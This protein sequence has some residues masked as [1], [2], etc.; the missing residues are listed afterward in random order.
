MV[1]FT[2]ASNTCV[3]DVVWLVH[4]E[5]TGATVATTTSCYPMGFTNTAMTTATNAHYQVYLVNTQQQGLNGMLAQQ[6]ALAVTYTRDRVVERSAEEI[7]AHNRAVDEARERNQAR[8]RDRAQ[9]VDRARQLLLSHLTPAQR[10]T[11]TKN[12]WFVVEG[13]RSKQR[14]RIDVGGG[15]QGNVALLDSGDKVAATFCGHCDGSIP[16]YD[17]FLAQKLMLEQHE[18]EFLRLSNRRAVCDTQ[19]TLT[20]AP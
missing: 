9:A 14:Y 17:Q 7:A 20:F 8:E 15:Y 18:D 12:R 5:C 3:D 16:R 1:A 2:S 6:G 11:F 10:E 19:H 4:A 13:G